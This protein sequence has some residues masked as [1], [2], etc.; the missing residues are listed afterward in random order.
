MLSR[1]YDRKDNRLARAIVVTLTRRRNAELPLETLD[2]LSEAFAL[3]RERSS[4]EK[5]A[6]KQL[7]STLAIL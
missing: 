3:I 2:A 1:S 6:C 4:N 7:G 5:H